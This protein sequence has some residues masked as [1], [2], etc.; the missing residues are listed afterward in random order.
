MVEQEHRLIPLFKNWIGR[1]VLFPEEHDKRRAAS[2]WAL[3]RNLLF[4]P[5]TVAISG[6]FAA[7]LSLCLLFWQNSLIRES[8]S[9]LRKSA[10]PEIQFTAVVRPTVG[11]LNEPPVLR[12]QTNESFIPLRI[13]QRRFSFAFT[14]NEVAPIL[15]DVVN[16]RVDYH[17]EESGALWSENF[18]SDASV[19]LPK[20][21][22][23]T[24]ELSDVTFATRSVSKS[25]EF[26]GPEPPVV[27]SRI[28]FTFSIVG[29]DHRGDYW[30]TE[31][32]S[33]VSVMREDGIEY[34]RSPLLI[35]SGTQP[36]GSQLKPYQPGVSIKAEGHSIDMRGR[37]TMS[38]ELK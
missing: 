4:S 17:F 37:E 33:R 29:I 32:S 30:S 1:K 16:L 9:I 28:D 11:R 27:C 19:R 15:I 21:D 12:E 18:Q 24:M 13:E 7:F 5:Q 22:R 35:G 2:S 34:A 38:I 14:A 10:S 26:L 36:L 20:V 25:E 23:G 3:V 31:I 8:N 6:T